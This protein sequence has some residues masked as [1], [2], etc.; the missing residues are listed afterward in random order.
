VLV[1]FNAFFHV[2]IIDFI[3]WFLLNF[4]E[5]VGVKGLDINTDLR[6]KGNSE[7][8][9]VFIFEPLV[10]HNL[11]K[12]VAEVG[13]WDQY[14]LDQVFDIVAQ[15]ASEFIARIQNFLVQTLSVRVFKRQVATQQSKQ[16]YA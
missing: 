1:S 2:R 12:A 15:K 13:I 8:G 3:V 11:F 5:N 9:L 14:I 10:R 7:S 16:D 4:E 6:S